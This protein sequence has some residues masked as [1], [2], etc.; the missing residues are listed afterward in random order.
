MAK[1]RVE[2]DHGTYEVETEEPKATPP[3]PQG[4]QSDWSIGGA[5]QGVGDVVGGVASTVGKALVNPTGLGDDIANGQIDLARRAKQDYQ[6]GHKDAALFHGVM[7]AIPGLGPAIANVDDTAGRGEYSRALVNGAALV[8]PEALGELSRVAPVGKAVSRVQEAIRPGAENVANELANQGTKKGRQL[9]EK[10][11]ERVEQAG[12][13]G[14]AADVKAKAQSVMDEV[15]RKIGTE[16]QSLDATGKPVNVQAAYDRL[17]QL[18]QQNMVGETPINDAVHK[19]IEGFQNKLL[20][21]ATD[22]EAGGKY[23][24]INKLRRDWDA[25]AAGGTNAFL[26]PAARTAA[27]TAKAA[28]NSVREVLSSFDGA[29]AINELNKQF[30]VASDASKLAET[31]KPFKETAGPVGKLIIKAGST[32]A[33]GVAGSILGH[34]VIGAEAGYLIAPTL[35]RAITSGAIKAA[36]RAIRNGIADAIS[37]GNLKLANSMAGTLLK[38]TTADKDN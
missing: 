12:Y 27:K 9:Y 14:K 21:V 13:A 11:G 23:S 26:D 18:K 8:V 35:E 6:A 30:S 29:E 24:S 37:A 19:Q 16:E 4:K 20:Q 2:T 28:S 10:R 38:R 1:Y 31:A 5:L 7:S 33:G 25:Q 17:E 3:Q 15:G 22:P 32:A 36:P 34:P